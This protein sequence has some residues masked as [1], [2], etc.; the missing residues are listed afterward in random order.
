MEDAAGYVLRA[1]PEGE[2]E[3]FRYHVSECDQ[4]AEKVDELGFVSHA[5]LNAVE[6]LSAPP[7]IRERVM[8]TVRAE[9]ELLQAA[10]AGADRPQARA[11]RRFAFAWPSPLAA[12]ALAVVLLALG[13]GLGTLLRGG[14][15]SSCTTRAANVD[16]AAGAGARGALKVCDG[17]ATLAL[18]GMQAPPKGRIYELW[19]DNPKDRQGP[20]PAGLFSVR[21]GRASVDVGD[22]GDG[23]AVL[24]TD[25]PLPSGS[26]IPTRTPI[27]QAV[28]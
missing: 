27:V 22:I 20:S 8:A 1:L 26:E 14:P 16:G 18:T 13:L 7:E 24:V 9:A 10:G 15:D 3:A 2:W 6:Q 28:S 23:K 12:G 17:N 4:C 25:E 11:K 5:M 21:N 19:L